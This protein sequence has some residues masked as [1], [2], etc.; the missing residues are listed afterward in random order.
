MGGDFTSVIGSTKHSL[1]T[2]FIYSENISKG[3][4]FRFRYR[5]LNANGWSDFSPITHLK[6]ATTP[7]R[8]PRPQFISADSQKVTMQLF[9]SDNDGG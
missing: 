9:E 3:A 5:C 2:E 1:E 6:A 4:I 7:G 8:P